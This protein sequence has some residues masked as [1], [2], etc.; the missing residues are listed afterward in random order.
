MMC[1][2]ISAIKPWQSKLAALSPKCSLLTMCVN[3]VA[4]VAVAANIGYTAFA[5]YSG[6]R[7]II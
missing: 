7:V 1:S 2:V 6:R 3:Y 4:L 5:D